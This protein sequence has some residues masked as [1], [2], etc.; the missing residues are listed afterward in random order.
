MDGGTRK[1][2]EAKVVI[3]FQK[4]GPI[5]MGDLDCRTF[6]LVVAIQ[7]HFHSATESP[8]HNH[9]SDDDMCTFTSVLVIL[10]Y[11]PSSTVGN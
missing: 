3:S 4:Q 1:G 5:F 8:R 6:S 2:R 10:Y 11:R 9:V 7:S